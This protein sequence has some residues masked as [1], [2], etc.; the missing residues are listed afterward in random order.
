MG[1]KEIVLKKGWAGRTISRQETAERVNPLVGELIGLMCLY[2]DMSGADT[3][4]WKRP[5]S[6]LK[7]DV[8]KLCEV[9]N[10][11]GGHALTGADENFQEDGSFSTDTI[12]EREKAFGELL[13]AEKQFEHQMRTRA[14]LD[15]VAVNSAD[16]VKTLSRSN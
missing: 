12:L 7:M 2:G 5:I 3:E 8:G 13:R 4:Q 6:V 11:N 10:S 15:V 14:I 9:V 1:I 16:R